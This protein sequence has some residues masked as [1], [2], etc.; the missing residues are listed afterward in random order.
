MSKPIRVIFGVLMGCVA[1]WAQGST[2]QIN[3]TVRDASGLAVPGADVKATQTATSAVRTVTSG[4]DGAFVFANLPI[5]PYQLE[6]NKVGFAQYVQSG[7]VLQVA[8][9]PTVDV[10]LKV[11]AVSEQVVI[12]ANA[13]QVET[14][15]TGL[16]QVIDNQRVLELPLNGRNV[17]Q[18]IILSGAAVGGGYQSSTRGYPT[19]M[20]SVG[21][22]LNNGLTYV[23]DGGTH[24]DPY[25]NA[26]LPL[27]F[28]D[29]LQEFKVETSSV[30][31]QYGQHSAGA[32]TAVTKS[33]TNEF[34]GDLFEFVR[35]K[36]FNARNTFAPTVDGLKRNQFGGVLGG[37]IVKNKLFFFFGDQ[38]TRVRSVPTTVIG[39]IPN[40][41]MLA[42][43]WTTIATA[44]G[45]VTTLKAPFVN[46]QISPALFSPVALNLIKHFPTTTDPCGQISFGRVNNSNE[47]FIVGRADY[48]QSAKNSLFGRYMVARLGQLSD[49]DGQDVLSLSQPNYTRR[50]HSFVLGDTYLVSNSMV[51]S[52]RATLLRLTNVKTIPDFFNF[53]DLGVQNIYSEPRERMAM[54]NA[55]GQFNI[56]KATATPGNTNGTHY[57]LAE[58]LSMTHGA[59]QIGFGV[60]YIHVMMNYLGGTTASGAFGFNT[61]NTGLTLGDFMLG[62]PSSWAQ[63]QFAGWYPRENY[64]ALYVQDT[65]KVSSRLTVIA[66]LRWE[67]YL[68]PYTNRVQTAIFD[69]SWYL[70]GLHSSVF[71]N[72]PVGLLF[73]GDPG[74]ANST[75]FSPNSWFHLAPRLGLSWDP[76]GDGKTVV[77]AAYGKF[78]DYAHIDAYGD[79]QNSPPS[80]G[81][82]SIPSPAGGFSDPWLG[83]PGGNPF[84]LTFGPNAVF[85]PSSQ[86]TN[87]PPGIKH[88]YINQWN[89][90]IQKQLGTAWLLSGSYLGNLGVHEVLAYEGN[91]AIYVPGNNCS[92]NGVTYSTCSTTSNTNQRR[93]LSLE[94]P[95]QGA[96]FSNIVQ[97]GDAGTR[98]YNALVL[99]AQ[100][101]VA[102]GVS[103]LANYTWS[104]CI[105]D[106]QTVDTG[107]STG[108]WA[109]GRRLLDRGNCELD[110]RQ[111]FNLSTVYQTPQFSNRTVRALGT[112]WQVSGIVRLLSGPW[113][114]VSSGL[115]NALTATGDQTPNQVLPSPYAAN[116]SINGWLNPAAFVQPATGTYGNMG[117][118]NILG[119]GNIGVDM[120]V[121]RTFQIRERQSLQFRAEV[122][123]LPN[124][125][126]PLTTPTPGNTSVGMDLNISDN[127][128]GRILTAGDPRIM[129]MALKFVF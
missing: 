109:A 93:L 123:N 4:A 78:F 45:K 127:A 68:S 89:L 110:R 85:I 32:V 119:P 67:P 15:A 19:D 84:P 7:I 97:T 98:S 65:W 41:Q 31:A 113:L 126:N 121:T 11:G 94:N 104:H 62:K 90:S 102:K 70:Q 5:G 10:A 9:N 17:Q 26:N 117:R 36:I 106:G 63:G 112:G 105:D 80:G 87:V 35:N 103:V 122:F 12:E 76:K 120:G 124:H 71:K 40:Q 49:Y 48:Q 1:V 128:F 77:R 14:Q 58:D 129:Q 25:V 88:S 39:F 100:H 42:G 83:V 13:V 52:F 20:I 55:S 91:P 116:K 114:T 111:N 8:S 6:V 57:Q 61:Q 60:S 24:N 95:S 18:L 28:P 43:D 34:H 47:Q 23:L 27:P 29:A 2:A 21:G 50:A 72:A 73:P 54:V 108:G 75:S 99:S 53:S 64:A 51:S 46:N 16:G 92:I 30:P 86:Y 82:T 96:Y 66:G 44:C 33:G 107:G 59:H 74:V 56:F 22:G 125:V 81:R 118:Q 79:L 69:N 3:G 101:R 37:P 115:D 38:F